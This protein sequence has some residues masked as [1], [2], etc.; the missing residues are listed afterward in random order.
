MS[1]CLC[2]LCIC[3][4]S[5]NSVNLDPTQFAACHV[6]H[7]SD[8]CLP[9]TNPN[10]I[11]ISNPIQISYPFHIV[12]HLINII[13]ICLFDLIDVDWHQLC[14]V[15]II[16][17]N[18]SFIVYIYKTLHK[19]ISLHCSS[20]NRVHVILKSFMVAYWLV[21]QSIPSTLLFWA[22]QVFAGSF[23][24]NLTAPVLWPKWFWHHCP[25]PPTSTERDIKIK[26][27]Q[28]FKITWEK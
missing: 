1:L 9:K 20:F 15:Y 24:L 6:I 21:C 16:S 23:L 27:Y 19:Q 14:Y 3:I 7:Q 28:L 18:I 8:N 25:C 11:S 10:L 5:H 17:E 4:Q 2:S 13:M 22:F 26:A 12:L